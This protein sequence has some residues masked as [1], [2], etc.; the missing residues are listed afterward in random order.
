MQNACTSNCPAT[1]YVHPFVSRSARAIWPMPSPASAL[2][3]TPAASS[4]SGDSVA[5]F[6][7]PKIAV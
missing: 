5:T 3:A 1:L 6:C 4:V 2:V 7:L